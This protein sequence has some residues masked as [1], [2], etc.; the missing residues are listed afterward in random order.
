MSSRN[1]ADLPAKFKPTFMDLLLSGEALAQDVDNF[2][3]TWHDAP[4]G[5]EVASLSIEEFLGM[6][7]DEYRLWVEQPDS[8]RFIVAAHKQGNL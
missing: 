2:I 5:S 3:D 4:D 7:A 6:T 1:S 8:L